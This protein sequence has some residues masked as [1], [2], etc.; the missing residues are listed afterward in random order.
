[1]LTEAEVVFARTAL[2]GAALEAHL[3]IRELAEIRR[4]AGDLLLVLRLDVA[5]IE[6]EVDHALTQARIGV[7]AVARVLAR[8][9]DRCGLGDR[10]R[11][12]FLGRLHFLLLGARRHAG[13]QQ[14][15]C[16]DADDVFH[17]L[18]PCSGGPRLRKADAARLGS[19]SSHYSEQLVNVA[20]TAPTPV[21]AHRLPPIPGAAG[22]GHRPRRRTVRRAIL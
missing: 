13:D 2:V 17:F 4:M 7:E 5:A 14:R 22:P 3:R 8:L 19:L 18:T 1:T 11:R 20:G 16:N 21:R 15:C 9:L 12:R 6:I 10:W